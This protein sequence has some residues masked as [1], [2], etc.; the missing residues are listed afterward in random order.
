MLVFLKKIEKAVV[1]ALLIMMVIT[2]LLA[3]IEVG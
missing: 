2:V 1:S 3:T